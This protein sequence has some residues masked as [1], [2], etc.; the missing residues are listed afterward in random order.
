MRKEKTVLMILTLF[1]ALFLNMVAIPFSQ[2][3]E[4][5][6]KYGGT[7][8][9]Q[10]ANDPT[11][12]LTFLPG[13]FD[14]TNYVDLQIFNRLF[15]QGENNSIVPDLVKSWDVSQ[16]GL[17]YTF[18]IH[19]DVTFHDGEPL[20]SADIKWSYDYHFN[21]LDL[22]PRWY[23]VESIEATDTYT[24]VFK[25]KEL[26][27]DFMDLMR[28]NYMYILP[29]HL[30]EGYENPEDFVNNPYNENPIGSGPFKFAEWVKED[31]VTLVANDDYFK[32][33]PYLDRVIFKVIPSYATSVAA[34]E[35]G[36]VDTLYST[37]PSDAM[38]LETLPGIKVLKFPGT[39]QWGLEFNLNNPILSNLKVRQAFAYAIDTYRI[40]ELAFAGGPIPAEDAS[41]LAPLFTDWRSPNAA[42]YDYDPVKAEA[43]LD[44][45]G[46][47]RGSDGVRFTMTLDYCPYYDGDEDMW[48]MVEQ[49]LHDVGIEL[50]L[51]KMDWATYYALFRKMQSGEHEFELNWCWGCCSPTTLERAF[52]SQGEINVGHYNNS[53]VDWLVEESRRTIDENQ[54]KEYVYEIQ[55]ITSREL[56]RFPLYCQVRYKTWNADFEGQEKVIWFP[57]DV[58]W[59]TEGESVSPG[60]ASEAIAD[61]ETQLA[62]LEGKG[63]KVEEAL[64]KLDDAKDALDEGKYAAAY[65]L[66]NEALDLAEKPV[67]Y[68]LYGAVAAVVI[69]II[70]VA[71][72]YLKFRTPS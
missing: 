47:P 67:P 11:V 8:I 50:I 7:L 5:T 43:L 45:A 57:F 2:G 21:N 34:I 27:V 14:M 32:G 71:L 49:Y 70:A 24:I 33:R 28:D 66:A 56:P 68:T 53:R 12:L 44:E 25:L 37:G 59:W 63:W 35:A 36:E 39:S 42:K 38:R 26:D 10:I 52:Y 22:V 23:N 16:D 30:Y 51:N 29:K 64:A 31:H 20:T 46:Y 1:S 3:Q 58:V 48:L 17:T 54:R 15:R 55:D 18:H 13:R 69:V 41:Y 72:W 62:E 19:E 40:V 61:T 9:V 65:S 60:T 4:E 6:P